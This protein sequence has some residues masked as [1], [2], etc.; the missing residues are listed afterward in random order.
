MI[1]VKYADIGKYYK[2]NIKL[3]LSERSVDDKLLLSVQQRVLEK[4]T[5]HRPFKLLL[6]P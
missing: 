2:W 3:K 5:A 4:A 6:A 1:A